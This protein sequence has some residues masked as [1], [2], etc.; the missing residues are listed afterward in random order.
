M[1]GH[2][3]A[4]RMSDSRRLLPLLLVGLPLAAA[5]GWW[6][7]PANEPTAA[8]D[9]EVAALQEQLARQRQESDARLARIERL[10][11]DRADGAVAAIPPPTPA[12]I[13][14]NEALLRQRALDNH[15]RLERAFTGPAAGTTDA[16]G[17]ARIRSA[18]ASSTVRELID[19]PLST[20]VRC[21]TH[22][23]AIR[24]LFPPGTDAESWTTG[25]SQALAPDF[26]NG[27]IA[28][29]QSPAG[30]TEATLYTVR[31]GRE[32]LLDLR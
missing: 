28:V 11:A 3:P 6:V 21:R 18:I 1:A 25:L 31:P 8:G 19:Q 17:E 23:C 20:E 10:L 9:G 5:L 16:K 2:A 30:D 24:V 29:T 13:A 4:H 27:R 7:R 15:V 22:I 32:A 26:T 12:E 14:K